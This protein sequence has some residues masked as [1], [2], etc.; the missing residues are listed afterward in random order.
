LTPDW[1]QT[2]VTLGDALAILSAALSG[3]AGWAYNLHRQRKARR[4]QLQADLLR[5]LQAAGPI[6]PLPA[7]AEWAE[8]ATLMPCHRRKRLQAL[9]AHYRTAAGSTV[10]DPLGQPLYT[11]G[12]RVEACKR[13]LARMLHPPVL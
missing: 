2:Q 13:M 12:R 8:L 7:Q 11:Q 6:C 5:A 9:L 3:A 10:D 1:W 4:L